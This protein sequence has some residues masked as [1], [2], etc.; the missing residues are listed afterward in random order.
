M[1]LRELSE[2][3]LILEHLGFEISFLGDYNAWIKASA[4]F[5][6]FSYPH[7]ENNNGR[8]VRDF[9]EEND[10]FC[11]NPLMWNGVREEKLTYQRDMGSVYQGSILDIG[12]ATPSSFKIITDFKVSNSLQ[13][14]VDS[15]HSSL[16]VSFKPLVEIIELGEVK[17]N[18]FKKIKLWEKFS[19]I[20]EKRMCILEPEFDGLSV[21]EQG[22]KITSEFK[23]VGRSLVPT[24]NPFHRPKSKRSVLS[25]RLGKALKRVAMAR[26]RLRDA[27][28]R[29][30]VTQALRLAIKMD[31]LELTQ[32]EL[33]ERTVKRLRAKK[34]LRGGDRKATQLFWEA[35]SGKKKRSSFIS[36]LE[37]GG[38]V[39]FEAQ[40]KARII[41][42]FFKTKFMTQD[43][44]VDQGLDFIYFLAL[45]VLYVVFT[46]FFVLFLLFFLLL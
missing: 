5:N 27:A 2:E 23:A 40:A 15:D 34:L 41:E 20:L 42:D 19:E 13:W 36:A 39:V 32:A 24:V 8:L 10:L 6:F 37:Q 7:P 12:M 44:P 17:V 38:E 16:V 46:S 25:P 26:Q 35:V 9:A 18:V 33:A 45:L 30:Q 43:V 3:K 1:L 28:D 21:K 11:L 14:S 4:R 29:G 31:R 22:S